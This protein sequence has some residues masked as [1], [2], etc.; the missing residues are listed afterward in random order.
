MTTAAPRLRRRMRLR[1]P[2][3]ALVVAV[4]L[5]GCAGDGSDPLAATSLLAVI[6][7]DIFDPKCSLPACHSALAQQGALNLADVDASYDDLVDIVSTCVGLIL[8]VPE[9]TVASY[10]L[11]KLTDGAAFCGTSS[12]RGRRTQSGPRPPEL[13]TPVPAAARRRSSVRVHGAGE[14]DTH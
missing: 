8:V 4:L 14:S 13:S 12:G 3:L 2:T 10:L 6:Q 1:N 7:R 11:D 9:N 5:S